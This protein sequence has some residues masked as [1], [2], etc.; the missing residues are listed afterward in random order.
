MA[1]GQGPANKVPSVQQ[2]ETPGTGWLSKS[3]ALLWVFRHS[4]LLPGK[5]RC[6]GFLVMGTMS[7]RLP[8]YK[9]IWKFSLEPRWTY[10][11]AK[12]CCWLP[13]TALPSSTQVRQRFIILN[14]KCQPTR[15][16]CPSPQQGIPY[17]VCVSALE[18][19]AVLQKQWSP[20]SGPAFCAFLS[21]THGQGVPGL[22]T[23]LETPSTLSS[24]LIFRRSKMPHLEISETGRVS[25]SNKQPS[26]Q[27]GCLWQI[28]SR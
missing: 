21:V 6:S 25:I 15:G 2:T 8:G 9:A 4:L 18:L 28:P 1:L 13:D 24:F 17:Q 11:E 22:N 5:Q 16:V 26:I 19:S 23:R 20:S 12:L 7:R 14:S 3:W 27:S 10:G